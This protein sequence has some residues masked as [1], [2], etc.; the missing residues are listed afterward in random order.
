MKKKNIYFCRHT[1]RYITNLNEKIRT[2]E[3]L[4]N[5]IVKLF[6]LL[7]FDL[8]VYLYYNNLI[9]LVYIFLQ[10]LVVFLKEI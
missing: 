2:K 8:V 7:Y 6:L 4:Y 1:C 9:N 10:I 3:W 5:Y